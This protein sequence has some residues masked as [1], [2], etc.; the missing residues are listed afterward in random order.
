[1][2]VVKVVVGIVMQDNKFLVERRLHDE[3]IDPD[4]VCLPGGH[5]EPDESL[6]D[7]LKR[8]LLEELNIHVNTCKYISR[9]FHVASNG[10]KEDAYYF[11]V[12]EY[13]GTIPCQA[14]QELYWEDKVENLTFKVD[15]DAIHKVLS[16]S[17]AL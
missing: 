12:T 17:P 9:V 2:D 1:M 10:E 4:V 7:A 16:N 11:Y 3:V 15:R 6:E 14:A 8:E 13:Q 5:V